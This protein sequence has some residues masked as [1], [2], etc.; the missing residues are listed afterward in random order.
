[1]KKN[2]FNLFASLSIVMVILV[3][4]GV[5]NA[6]PRKAR[7]NVYTKSEVNQIINNLETRL[8]KFKNDF[9]TSLD[10][11]RL[12]GTDREDYLNRRA[13]DLER[14]TDELRSEF[15]RR[16]K[17][18]ENK[19]EVRK[20]LNIAQDI[21]KAMKNRKLGGKTENNWSAVRYEL[22]TLA[23]IYNLPTVK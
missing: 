5:T 19:A 16:D 3:L 10:H 18:S 15:D 2:L 8:D 21:N 12:N 17:W 9:D 7:G 13:K 6:Q 1:M 22:N 20:C 11:S 23:K 4:A 14:A